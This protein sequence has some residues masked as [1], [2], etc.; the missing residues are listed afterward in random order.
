MKP[1]SQTLA[2]KYKLQLK[3]PKWTKFS[4]RI[5]GLRGNVCQS[6]RLAS[7]VTH[8]HHH[9]YEGGRLPWEYGT[10]EV[11]VL[12]PACHHKM[13]SHLKNFRQFI[14]PKLKPREFQILNGALLVALEH[15]DTLEVMHA[16][17][18]MCA[19]PSSIKRF[20][21]DAKTF[22]GDDDDGLLKV[23]PKS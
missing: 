15:N 14:F 4:D 18:S 1:A 10:G 22:I 9:F 17:A 16:L 3:D 7:D 21:Y 13:H 8:V 12:C 23:E 20:A 5:K 6:C 11:S 2:E 19:S